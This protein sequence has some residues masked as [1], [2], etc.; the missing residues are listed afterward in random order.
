MTPTSTPTPKPAPTPVLRTERLLLAPYTPEDE[1]DFVALFQD[2][3]VSRWMGDGPAGEDEDRALFG[4]IFTKVYAGNLFDVWAVR[5]PDRRLV[6]HA[7]IKRT[8]EV[9]GY[10]IIYALA[11]EAWG[12]GLGT[13]LAEAIVAYGFGTLG[14]T[15]VHATVAEPNKASLVVLERLGFEHVRDITEDDGS[16]T[17]VLT[18]RAGG[19]VG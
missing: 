3:R 4:R 2:P 9:R 6:G 16:T 8:D 12:S 10:E 17:R 13:E 15:E 5:R 14:L 18:R 1:E 11:P 7:E 19:P